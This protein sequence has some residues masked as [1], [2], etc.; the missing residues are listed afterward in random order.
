MGITRKGLILDKYGWW[1]E[2]TQTVR[3]VQTWTV[4]EKLLAFAKLGNL[5]S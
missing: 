4:G 2:K 1:K 3:T 5:G